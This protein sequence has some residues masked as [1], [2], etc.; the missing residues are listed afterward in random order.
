VALRSDWIRSEAGTSIGI[1]GAS[2]LA[3][4]MSSQDVHG[5]ERGMKPC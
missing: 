2:M 5:D 4:D 3:N 1:I